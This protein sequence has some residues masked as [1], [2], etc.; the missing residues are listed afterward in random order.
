MFDNMGKNATINIDRTGGSRRKTG[1]KPPVVHFHETFLPKSA[2]PAPFDIH[3]LRKHALDRGFQD[4]DTEQAEH[5]LNRI[6]YQH[7]S[8]YFSLF[9]DGNGG[10][11]DDAS[12][13]KLHRVILFDRKLQVLLM[14]YIGLFELQF[15]A[16]YS[17]LLSME[18]GAFAHRNPKN[19][20][21]QKHF[22][23]FLKRYS[24][25]FNRQMKNRNREIVSAYEKYGD[26]P[27]WLAVEIMSFG[28]LS[29]LYRN[30]RSRSVRDNVAA[31]FG[32]THDELASWTR[33]IS[34]VR[35]QCAHF[36]QLCGRTLISRPKKVAGVEGDNG[37]PFYITIVLEKLLS[38]R[39]FFADDASLSYELLMFR[40]VLQLFSDYSDVLEICRIPGNWLDSIRSDAVLDK[41]MRSV[42]DM[43]SFG[44]KG[45]VHIAV[46]CEDTGDV[47]E[48][49]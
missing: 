41:P 10:I 49:D 30:T 8:G 45:R 26:A 4:G 43:E 34:A 3:D 5:F 31:S 23:T 17:Y 18:R 46:N 20:K 15:R 14:E 47:V 36:G 28:T 35:N 24:E 32:V 19:F 11:S 29:M 37:N 22:A 21:E 12:L 44:Q 16:Q 2:A 7:A 33:A 13:M 42:P 6:S 1:I 9:E 38:S 25:E 39:S 48:I 27:T 40:D